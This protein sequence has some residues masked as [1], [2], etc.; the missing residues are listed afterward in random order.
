MENPSL[1]SWTFE[2]Y[3]ERTETNSNNSAIF[4]IS[5][6]KDLNENCNFSDKTWSFS[7]EFYDTDY[8]LNHSLSSYEQSQQMYTHP[9]NETT[10]TIVKKSELQNFYCNST[11]KSQAAN[12]QIKTINFKEPI[13]DDKI[14]SEL[15]FKLS[16]KE[17][18]HDEKLLKNIKQEAF[19]QKNKSLL[20]EFKKKT[21]K[22]SGIYEI[23]PLIKVNA[24]AQFIRGHNKW[25]RS[26][27]NASLIFKKYMKNI[28]NA[29]QDKIKCYEKAFN[30]VTSPENS[31]LLDKN[32]MTKKDPV[33]IK[34]KEKIENE[35]QGLKAP[36]AMFGGYSDGFCQEY[37]GN[38][39]IL[40]SFRLYIDFLFSIEES[41]VLCETMKMF[42]CENGLY[43]HHEIECIEKWKRLKKF[44]KLGLL[45]RSSR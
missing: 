4:F 25:V 2:D 40:K 12:L 29:D 8:G 45:A 31:H 34:R 36:K 5:A 32:S 7:E 6:K 13:Q 17:V 41:I 21:I 1:S 30:Y 44:L 42:C 9:S 39:I 26:I 16:F 3:F 20:K 22:K 10:K 43:G 19:F 11:S 15:L 35:T 38:P 37:F 18:F 24:R 27:L 28:K 14:D 33:N 23:K